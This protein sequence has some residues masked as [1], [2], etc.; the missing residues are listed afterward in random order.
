MLVESILGVV[1]G[2]LGPMITSFVN[3]K[4]QQ[5]KN[6][7]DIKMA[8]ENRETIKIEAEMSIKV[9]EAKVSGE[10]E[11]AEIGALKESYKEANTVMFDRSYME[12]LARSKWFSWVNHIIAL[13][14]ASIDFLKQAARPLIT[15]YMLGVSTYLTLLCY[16]FIES[17]GASAFKLTTAEQIF[18]D[19]VN[20]LL[21]LTITIVTWWFGQR[22][23]SKFMMRLNDGNAKSS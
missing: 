12:I 22:P 21:Y 19:S 3:Y 23:I 11:L 5:L 8:A 2:L 10:I 20:A 9:T 4:T 17:M 18:S 14:F 6:D 13:M 1:S 7:Y 16:K 15:Y